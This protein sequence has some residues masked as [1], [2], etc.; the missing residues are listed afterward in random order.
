MA[1]N[2][3]HPKARTR[4]SDSPTDPLANSRT[5]ISQNPP[6]RYWIRAGF[7]IG[8]GLLLWGVVFS[9]IIKMLIGGVTGAAA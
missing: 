1:L 6:F 4:A 3:A 5:P 2:P 7:G 8:I 9:L